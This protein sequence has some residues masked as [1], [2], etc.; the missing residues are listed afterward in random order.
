MTFEALVIVK[1]SKP[2]QNR[3]VFV[4]DLMTSSEVLSGIFDSEFEKKPVQHLDVNDW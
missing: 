2:R 3:N 4:R 1:I